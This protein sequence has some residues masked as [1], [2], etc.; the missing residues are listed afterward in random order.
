MTCKHHLH[1]Y[2]TIALSLHITVKLPP[3]T[4]SGVVCVPCWGTEIAESQVYSF[5]VLKNNIVFLEERKR[6]LQV[7]ARTA[8]T[9]WRYLFRFTRSEITVFHQQN[10]HTA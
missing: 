4:Q 9:R 8:L 1:S 5:T 2:E 10:Q 6:K 3:P 7:S